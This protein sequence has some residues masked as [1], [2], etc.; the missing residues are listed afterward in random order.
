MVRRFAGDAPQPASAGGD[1]E[2]VASPRSAS[3]PSRERAPGDAG[4]VATEN[5]SREKPHTPTAT[6][7]AAFTRCSR[8]CETH[9]W[10]ESSRQRS[11]GE[12]R[13]WAE[14]PRRV[15]REKWER[16]TSAWACALL[17]YKG[18]PETPSTDAPCR[19]AGPF[20]TALLCVCQDA[21]DAALESPAPHNAEDTAQRTL[22]SSPK[23]R[24]ARG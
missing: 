14:R 23:R 21:S 12:G 2:R 11:P 20:R 4:C 6:P 16:S 17:M 18:C 24:R 13:G 9:S 7:T 5:R 10:W 15:L 1:S 8:R 22:H 19:T 3:S